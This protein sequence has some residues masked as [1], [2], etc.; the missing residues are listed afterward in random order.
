MDFSSLQDPA[1]ILHKDKR[2]GGESAASSSSSAASSASSST[3][4]SSS[5]EELLSHVFEV[6]GEGNMNRI[7]RCLDPLS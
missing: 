7:Y 4:A 3:T 1:S 2:E 5:D 6:I